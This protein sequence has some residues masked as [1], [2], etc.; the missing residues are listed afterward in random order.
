MKLCKLD[1]FTPPPPPVNSDEQSIQDTTNNDQLATS[2]DLINA[3]NINILS[4]SQQVSTDCFKNIDEPEV[5]KETEAPSKVMVVLND[6]Q[7]VTS[8]QKKSKEA[9]SS[10]VKADNSVNK[11][12]F[13]SRSFEKKSKFT[14]YLAGYNYQKY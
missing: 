8:V 3:K 12:N 10:K 2:P 5:I 9:E 13:A 6:E 14:F 4:D 11:S 7:Q 1:K